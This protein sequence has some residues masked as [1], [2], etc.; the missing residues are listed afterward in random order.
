M[1]SFEEQWA[2]A[3]KKGKQQAGKQTRVPLAIQKKQLIEEMTHYKDKLKKVCCLK[4]QKLI[5]ETAKTLI[6]IRAKQVEIQIQEMRDAGIPTTNFQIKKL[7]HSY[8]DDCK[9][10]LH[11][12]AIL[13]K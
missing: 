13:S 2:V 8:A 4:S 11:A 1:N 7:A 5:E 3:L 10:I 9:K 12:I 6:E